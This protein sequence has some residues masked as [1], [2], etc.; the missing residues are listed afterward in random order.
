MTSPAGMKRNA[1]AYARKGS[2]PSQAS[3]GRLRLGVLPCR[4]AFAALGCVDSYPPIDG[5][6]AAIFALAAVCCASLANFTFE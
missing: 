5:H 3:E 4:S 1:S 2:V 6:S